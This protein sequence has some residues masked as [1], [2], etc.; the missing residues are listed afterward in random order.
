MSSF[1][2]PDAVTR[3]TDN[4]VRQVPAVH[5][6]YQMAGL[7][8]H[9]S[10]LSDGR[11][12]VLGAG[13]GMELRA[14]AEAYPGWRF[15]GVDPSPEMLRLAARTLGTLASR[16]ELVHGYIDSAPETEFDGA[17]CLLT[18]HFLS[19]EE[20]LRTLRELKR[21]L[22]PGAPLVIAHHSVPDAV[23]EKL[24]WFHRYAAFISS[25]GMPAASANATADAIASRLPTLSPESEVE[26]LQQAGF[27]RPSLFYAAFTFRGW[28][29]YAGT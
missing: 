8:L 24:R 17:T 10:V 12:L 19:F 5:A 4:L 20:R 11:V 2:D 25:N 21:R 6:L 9:E 29:A 13:G 16:V 3:Y 7:L 14:F 26:L 23:D 27:E 22:K 28:I 1:S 15:V 18:L